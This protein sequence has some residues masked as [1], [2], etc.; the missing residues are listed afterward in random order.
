MET[1][2]LVPTSEIPSVVTPVIKVNGQAI[3]PTYQVLSLMV[4]KEINRIPYAKMTIKDGDPSLEDFPGSNDTVFEPGKELEV[5][6]GYA[7]NEDPVF[8]GIIT[9]LSIKIRAEGSS[10][11]RIE[12]RDAL[13]KT[14]LST[15]N[16]YFTDLSDSDSLEEILTQYGFHHNV[17]PSDTVHRSLVQFEA[18]DWDF[19]L[20]RSHLNGWHCNINDGSI[21][22][23]EP[24]FSQD[25]LFTVA[26]GASI[27]DFDGEIDIREQYAKVYASGWDAANQDLSETEAV[28]PEVPAQGNLDPAALAGVA[29]SPELRLRHGGFLLPE[30]LQAWAD[31]ELQRIRLAKV[32]GRVKFAGSPVVKP[33]VFLKLEGL[34]DRFNGPAYVSGVRHE[35]FGGT[36]Q[37]SAQL[38]M[39]DNWLS[40][41]MPSAAPGTYRSRRTLSGLQIGVVVQLEGDPDGENR[42]LIRMPLVSPDVEGTWARMASP[43]AGD[44]RGSVYYPEIGDEVVVGFLGGD[45]RD[46]V[47]LGMLFSSSKTAPLEATDENHEKGYYSRSGIKFRFDDDKISV[48]IESPAGKSIVLDEDEGVLQLADEN[49]NKIIMDSE[50]IRIVS[51]G[52]LELKATGDCKVEGGTNLELKAGASFKAEG[53]AGAEMTTS[54]IAVVKGSLV[55]IN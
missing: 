15:R 41:R 47:V 21:T 28:E 32:R 18:T 37:T 4:E 12:C 45:A 10:V 20:D 31:S 48:R 13:F 25:P 22:I 1:D 17:T 35:V 42:I 27:L 30:E 8:K 26:Y 3:S 2:R 34:G 36:W 40:E 52:K 5:L 29:N 44:G 7:A 19:I 6:L 33:G 53:S 49:N 14:T 38:G 9:A 43:D 24:D 46:P 50:G 39:P 54:A 55:Q 11:L 23:G 51:G 16:R